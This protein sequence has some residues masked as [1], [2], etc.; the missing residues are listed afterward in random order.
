MGEQKCLARWELLSGGPE[1]SLGSRGCDC[2]KPRLGQKCKAERLQGG[3]CF[4]CEEG[5]PGRGCSQ[6]GTCS[7]APPCPGGLERCFAGLQLHRRERDPCGMISGQGER[8][9]CRT[10]RAVSRLALGSC[11][12]WEPPLSSASPGALGSWPCFCCTQALLTQCPGK[13]GSCGICALWRWPFLGCSERRGGDLGLRQGGILSRWKFCLSRGPLSVVFLLCV[14]QK[15]QKFWS[16]VLAQ[17]TAGAT[18]AHQRRELVS[19]CSRGFLQ[20]LKGEG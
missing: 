7:S 10:G 1:V 5:Q 11:T 3:S 9:R 12:F 18:G 4:E 14:L 17:L 15:D 6:L 16:E 8:D 19:Q 2:A 20:G 13:E